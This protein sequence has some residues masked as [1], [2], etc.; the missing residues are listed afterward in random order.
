MAEIDLKTT[1]RDAEIQYERTRRIAFPPPPPT[2]YACVYQDPYTGANPGSEVCYAQAIPEPTRTDNRTIEESLAILRQ[3]ARRDEDSKP[4]ERREVSESKINLMNYYYEIFKHNTLTKVNVTNVV[5]SL[6]D[7]KAI[8]LIQ[9]LL[10]KWRYM[11]QQKIFDLI[12]YKDAYM[13]IPLNLFDKFSG[14][15]EEIIDQIERK[16]R[17]RDRNKLDFCFDEALYLLKLDG[18]H[19]SLSILPKINEINLVEPFIREETESS[20]GFTIYLQLKELI[21]K[22]KQKLKMGQGRRKKTLRKKYKKRNS[23]RLKHAKQT[24]KTTRRYLH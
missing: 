22:Q 21:E 15:Q 8:P 10:S 23:R 6:R 19:D 4:I 24:N 5:E 3:L 12:T 17:S 16:Y 9:P 18:S 14:T 11:Y 20:F 1:F 7:F 13:E 2:Q